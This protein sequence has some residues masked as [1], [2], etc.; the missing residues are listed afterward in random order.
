MSVQVN[1]QEAKT[2]LSRLLVAAVNGE[3]VIIARS[4][5]PVV[6]LQPVDAPS[7]RPLGFVAAEP[8]GA[9]FFEPLS[10]AELAEWEG[11]V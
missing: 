2:T 4:G 3:D 6:R 8:L 10:A 11:G 9:A 5:R 1:V 7:R